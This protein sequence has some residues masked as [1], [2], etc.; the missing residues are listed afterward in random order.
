[1][2]EK[3]FEVTEGNWEEVVV[4]SEKPTLVDFWAAWCGPCRIMAP[5]ME[6]LA[7]KYHGSLRVAKCNVEENYDIS[8]R[9]QI[10]SIPT[11]VLFENGKEKKRLVGAMSLDKL[12]EELGLKE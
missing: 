11:F 9:N 4:N 2:G 5:V 12:I 1:M 7:E 10:H 8:A 3:I 6:E